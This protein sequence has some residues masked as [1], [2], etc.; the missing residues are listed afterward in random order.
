MI[1]PEKQIHLPHHAWWSDTIKNVHL[2]VKY[3][4]TT[5]S[6]LKHP[7]S[8]EAV[9]NAILDQFG[10]NTDI[11][12]GDQQR[13]P[14]AQLQKAKKDQKKCR[15]NSYKLQQE[16]LERLTEEMMEEETTKDKAKIVKNIKNHERTKRMYRIMKQYLKPQDR[17][18]ITHLD[19]PEWNKFEF[20]T[21]SA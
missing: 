4:H 13:P 9:L 18:R 17:A 15:N 5:I 16:L 10:S 19:V 21:I 3:W 1:I 20:L 2:V 14:T 12:Q 6:I 7:Q 11:F 8:T